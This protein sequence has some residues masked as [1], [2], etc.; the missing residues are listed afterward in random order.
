M[1][2]REALFDIPKDRFN[3]ALAA[4]KDLAKPKA[5]EKASGGCWSN[6]EK[7]ESHYSWVNTNAL[8]NAGTLKEAVDACRWHIEIDQEG[9]CYNIYFDGEKIGDD[10]ILFEALAPFVES[11]GF[12]E[13]SGEDG[14]LWRWCFEDGKLVEKFA[15]ISWDN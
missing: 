1:E 6:G 3:D 7:T 2:M 11:G 14:A 10:M 12:I 13:M 15:T 9:D 8:A 4:V 5:L